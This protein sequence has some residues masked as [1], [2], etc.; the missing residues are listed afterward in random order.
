MSGADAPTSG[1]ATDQAVWQQLVML[2]R[3]PM[4]HP[5]TNRYKGLNSKSPSS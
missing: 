2:L 1:L 3:E 5:F 4:R